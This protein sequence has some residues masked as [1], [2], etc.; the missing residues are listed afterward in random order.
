MEAIAARAPGDAL[1]RYFLAIAHAGE[2]DFVRYLRIMQE[3]DRLRGEP[4]QSANLKALDAALKSGGEPALKALAIDQ[5]NAEEVNRPFTDHSLPAF[6]ASAA[7]D[8]ARLIATLELAD[9][10]REVWG[11]SG[12]VRRIQRRWAADRAIT[13]LLKRRAS[14][15]VEP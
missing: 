14:P 7:G 11:S 4:Q 5:A 8:R 9:R 12:Y 2:G 1:P 10:N 3:R 13:A 6:L 15:P